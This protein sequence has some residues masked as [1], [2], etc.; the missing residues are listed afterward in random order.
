MHFG[1]NNLGAE[2]Y[3]SWGALIKPCRNAEQYLFF[4][5]NKLVYMPRVISS[6]SNFGTN[7][8]YLDYSRLIWGMIN[9][10]ITQNSHDPYWLR[11]VW[12]HIF[13]WFENILIWIKNILIWFE[14]SLIWFENI[15]KINNRCNSL[16]QKA[17]VLAFL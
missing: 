6:I 8:Y 11:M 7:E 15:F 13:I 3:F 14:N 9:K 4:E 16:C 2:P 1:D 17:S 5:I 10:Q 12:K